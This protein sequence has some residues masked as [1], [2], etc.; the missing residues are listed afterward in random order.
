MA[1]EHFEWTVDY[2]AEAYI[3][4]LSTF[5]G[6]IAMLA[7][8]REQLFSEIRHRLSLRPQPTTA[9]RLRRRSARGPPTVGPPSTSQLAIGCRYAAAGSVASS[10]VH[11]LRRPF[12]AYG[13]T[14]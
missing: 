5:S 7:E 1:G 10:S 11:V 6:Y 9:P 8:R 12:D 4:L 13:M 2:D 3:R 14:N